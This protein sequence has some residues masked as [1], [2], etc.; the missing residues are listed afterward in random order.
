MLPAAKDPWVARLLADPILALAS[1][2][3]LAR[4]LPYLEE[5]R[6]APGDILYHAGDQ[7]Q[8][9]Y[10][11]LSGDLSLTPP[12]GATQAAPD[13]RAGEEASGEFDTHLTTAGTLDGATL[14]VLPRA[15]LR[16]FLSAQPLLLANLTQS[17][18]RIL[19][20]GSLASDAAASPG[21]A[22]AV[23]RKRKAVGAG[24][25]IGWL[26]TLLAPALVLY[27]APQW[28]LAP[29]AGHFLAIFS[30]T[31]MMWV[32]NLVDEYVPGVFAVLTTLAMGLVPIPVMLSGLASDGFLL[33]MSVLG[34]ATVIVASGLSYRLLL[35]LLLKLPN[36]PF[37]HNCGLLL[38]GFM[39]TPLV[40]S[41][42]GRVALLTPFYRDMLETLR[43]DFKS[44]SANRL[45]VSTFV[46]AGLLSAVFLSSKSVNF[47]VFGLLSDQ[48]Q[49][50]FQW[51]EWLKASAGAAAA[52][53]LTY[54][55]ASALYF[56][57]LPP[58]ALSKPQVAAQLSLL[59]RMK[60]REW[61]A[62][63]GV[64]LFMLGVATTS[65]HAIQ[66][67]W[68]GL[69]ILYGLLLFGSLTKEEF[70]EKIDWPFLLY[71]AGIVG[72]TAA[73]NHLGLTRLLAEKLP[74][75]GDIMRGSFPLFVLLL[76]GLIF[77][78]RLAVPISATIVILATLFM[79]V[80]EAHGVNPW[81]VGFVIL[82]LGEMWFF[83][84]QCS[85]YQQFQQLTR[86][87][88]FYD[89]KSFLRFNWLSNGLKLASVYASIPWWKMLGLL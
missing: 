4:L 79:P 2:T 43:L 24:T 81:V 63:G 75:L 5:R 46:G 62:F 29:H 74:E 53:L 82:V 84:Y 38:T 23:A 39:L 52:L 67:P 11:V 22:K 56:R 57:K 76:A 49:D 34:L 66:P 16:A 35:L 42:N 72:L 25:V 21:P 31:V 73:L 40:P 64:L 7:A 37:W 48:A 19:A 58:A 83:P 33:A 54:F 6:L 3:E 26:A 41:I 65:V 71:L 12:G 60:D 18:T 50:Q 85:Y 88:E 13:G 80:A 45:A 10:L 17:L 87:C 70:R 86:H 28:N 27:M 89:E 78:I 15:P 51:L 44:P 69:A 61:A 1:Y 59:G 36:T 55:L 8:A 47:V 9:L 20:G 30:A 68:L 14:L 77:V 32:F